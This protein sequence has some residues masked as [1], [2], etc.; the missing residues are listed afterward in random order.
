MYFGFLFFLDIKTGSL[1]LQL[2]LFQPVPEAVD[3]SHTEQISDKF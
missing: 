2:I 1:Q 3:E